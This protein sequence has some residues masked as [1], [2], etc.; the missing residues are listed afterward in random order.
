MSSP[1]LRESVRRSLTKG[2]VSGGHPAF[3][4]GPRPSPGGGVPARNGR[5]HPGECREPDHTAQRFPIWAPA[6][7]RGEACLRG[8]R[9]PHPGECRE[10]DHKAPRL[11]PPG[12]G[13][14]ARKEHPPS[15]RRPG[16][17][18][19]STPPSSAGERQACEE[20]APP[21]PAKAGNQITQH[22]ALRSG[23]RPPPG[24]GV[25]ARN[26]CPHPGERR[27]PDHGAPRVTIW[28]PAPAN[29]DA[30]ALF[31]WGRPPSK[32]RQRRKF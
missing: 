19:R 20:R 29:V 1:V 26:G 10:P 9:R 12:R 30:I 13:K 18:S 3:R 7:A 2:G 5:P 4:S 8:E 28:T 23:P 22:S 14:P 27:D 31:F 24:G 21:I 25:P 32:W 6:C 11:P 17:R 15:R 16:T